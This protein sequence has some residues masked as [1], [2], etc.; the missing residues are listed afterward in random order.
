MLIIFAVILVF[1]VVCIVVPMCFDNAVNVSFDIEV[2][3]T[4]NEGWLRI[5]DS[6]NYPVQLPAENLPNQNGTVV[7]KNTIPANVTDPQTILIRCSMQAIKIY[8]EG[9]EEPIYSQG[10]DTSAFIGKTLGSRWELVRLPSNCANKQIT[11]E[12]YSPID[13]FQGTVSEIHLGSKA[14]N[15]YYIVKT[16]G[17]SLIVAAFIFL[18]GVSLYAVYFAMGKANRNLKIIYLGMF[19]TLAALWITG[20]S[21]MLQFFF[22]NQFYVTKL[23][24]LALMLFPLPMVMYTKNAYST[25]NKRFEDYFFLAFLVNFIVC[26]I[27]QLTSVADFYETIIVTNILLIL[28]FIYE[29]AIGLYETVKNQNKDAR[30]FL[31]TSSVLLIFGLVEIISFLASNYDNTSYIFTIGMLVYCVILGSRTIYE[32][33]LTTAKS[34]ESEY[35]SKLAYTDLLTDCK[36]RNAYYVDTARIF[37]TATKTDVIWLITLDLN[38]LKKIND[39][40]GHEAGDEALIAVAHAIRDTFAP[41]TCYRTGGDEF[42]CIVFDQEEEEILNHLSQLETCLSKVLVHDISPTVAA[43]YAQFSEEG[44]TSFDV[45]SSL[46]DKRMYERKSEMR[47]LLSKTAK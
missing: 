37:A 39:R 24:Y 17:F 16:H 9:E 20:E 13:N 47:A 15:L 1:T 27:L 18:F 33:R 11:I 12:L 32:L 2:T 46:A 23:A 34:I 19:F 44:V 38:G 14:A 40:H 8:V 10:Y 22:E 5:T 36:N 3:D 29:V 31:L 6:G 42:I 30:D 28:F 41:Y 7:L 43:G 21:R 4:F 26:L 35:Y 45:L 25:Q